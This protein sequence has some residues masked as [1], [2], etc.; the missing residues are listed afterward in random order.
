[1]FGV[2]LLHKP[3]AIWSFGVVLLH[4][5]EA[6]GGDSDQELGKKW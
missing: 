3:E 1:M 6:V 4:K 2:V 5:S